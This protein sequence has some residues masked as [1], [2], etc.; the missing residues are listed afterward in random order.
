MKCQLIKVLICGTHRLSLVFILLQWFILSKKAT[1]ER[2]DS[3][4]RKNILFVLLFRVKLHH[5]HWPVQRWN[6]TFVKLEPF[7]NQLWLMLKKKHLNH[8]AEDSRII[9]ITVFHDRLQFLNWTPFNRLFKMFPFVNL[10]FAAWLWELRPGGAT[11]QQ[12]S[13]VYVWQRSIQPCLCVYQQRTKTRGGFT[14][15]DPLLWVN[16]RINHN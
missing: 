12:N 13:S 2:N 6:K 8:Q 10:C 11:I 16:E 1:V 5:R 15:M 3:L 7:S 14:M 4:D 9:I